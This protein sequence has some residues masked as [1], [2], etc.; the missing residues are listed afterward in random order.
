MPLPAVSP[1]QALPNHVPFPLVDSTKRIYGLTC[2]LK[3][4]KAL[5]GFS[6]LNNY[7]DESFLDSSFPHVKGNLSPLYIRGVVEENDLTGM[8][9]P[10]VTWI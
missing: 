4:E 5:F 6:R 10:R 9:L 3:M 7:I 1:P 8:K 2:V